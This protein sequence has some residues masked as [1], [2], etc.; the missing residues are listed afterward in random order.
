MFPLKPRFFE[1]IQNRKGNLWIWGKPLLELIR[2]VEVTLVYNFH[3]IWF[4]VAQESK[5]RRIFLGGPDISGNFTGYIRWNRTCPL[6]SFQ[7]DV[8]SLFWLY[9]TNRVSVW[10]HSS[11]A[12]FITLWGSFLSCW[13][14]FFIIFLQGFLLGVLNMGHK[15]V[16][17]ERNF[18]LLPFTPSGRPLGPSKSKQAKIVIG[19]AWA[20]IFHTEAVP[21]VKAD[22]PYF[23]VTV[24]ETQRWGKQRLLSFVVLCTHFYLHHWV[25]HLNFF[26][27]EGI[28]I[29]TGREID[30]PYLVSNEEEIKKQ[31]KSVRR[32]G[33]CMALLFYVIHGGARRRWASW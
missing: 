31:L 32:T 22:N 12:S 18:I 26:S 14:V 30:G 3:P 7:S 4:L 9:F 29:P 33:L 23:I 8:H 15:L 27:G 5:L 1:F 19:K 17:C 10:S 13:L 24:K 2:C 21:G 25:W 28:S 11:F 6:D 20:K 16:S